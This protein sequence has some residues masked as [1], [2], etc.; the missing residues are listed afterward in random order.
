MSNILPLVAV[1]SFRPLDENAEVARNQI[2]AIRSWDA[3]FDQIYLFGEDDPRLRSDKI[4]FIQSEPYPPISALIST[5]VRSLQPACIINADIVVPPHLRRIAQQA[6][7]YPAIAWTSKRAEFD[8]EKFNLDTAKVKDMGADIFC[9]MP[10]AWQRAWDAIPVGY[11]IGCPTWDSWLLGFFG[12]TYK[13]RFIDLTPLQPI[14]HPKHQ[15]RRRGTITA[16]LPRDK[17]ITSGLGFP[18]VY[19]R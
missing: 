15:E 3:A 13:R 18:L 19:H 17:Y 5:C 12:T 6:W 1:S 2:R 11:R 8:A 4:N 7:L 14:F 16:D 9:A 10:P